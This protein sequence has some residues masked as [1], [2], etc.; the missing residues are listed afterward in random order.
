MAQPSGSR[1][2]RIAVRQDKQMREETPASNFY[3]YQRGPVPRSPSFAAFP[4]SG[5]P[6]AGVTVDTELAP[7]PSGAG[8]GAGWVGCELPDVD[9]G[10]LEATCVLDATY[11]E[12]ATR[13]EGT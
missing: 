7:I 11:V 5:S 8:C 4:V 3:Y 9:E 13:V 6:P 12:G 1:M 10:Q 2:S